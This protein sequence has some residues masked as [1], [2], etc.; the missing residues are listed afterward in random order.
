MV[1]GFVNLSGR[2]ERLAVVF[3]NEFA[4]AKFLLNALQQWQFRPAKANGQIAAV[5]V[6]LIIPEE[7]E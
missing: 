3:P 4:K 7:T 5:E 6:L 2:F 1:H